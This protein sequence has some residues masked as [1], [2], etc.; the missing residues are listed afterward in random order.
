ME[1][2]LLLARLHHGSLN[3]SYHGL[4]RPPALMEHQNVCPGEIIGAV[5]IIILIN[6]PKVI[7][8]RHKFHSVTHW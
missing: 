3:S 2:K 1:L 5:C 4:H 8:A 6:W 7:F